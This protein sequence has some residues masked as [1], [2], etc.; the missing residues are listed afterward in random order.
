MA[1]EEANSVVDID[2]LFYIGHLTSNQRLIDIA[3]DH[4]TF[5]QKN[6]IRKD[7]STWHVVN[8][9]PRN[10]NL[11]SKHTHQG[12]SDESTWSRSAYPVPVTQLRVN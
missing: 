4:A 3:I 1:C 7:S 9:D 6:L 8:F 10:G 2:L 12:F 5:V 11:K